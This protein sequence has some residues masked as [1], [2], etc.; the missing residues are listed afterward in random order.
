LQALQ[1]APGQKVAG[2][3]TQVKEQVA[4]VHYEARRLA[5]EKKTKATPVAASSE[6]VAEKTA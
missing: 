4:A 1:T 6:P 5:D 3:A 2:V